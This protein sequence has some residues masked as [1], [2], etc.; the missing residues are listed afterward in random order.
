MEMKL[1]NIAEIYTG[2]T[3]RPP[4]KSVNT[5][6]LKT[7]QIKDLTKEQVIILDDQLVDLEWSYES[8]PQYLKH[9]SLIVV[10]R[11]EPRAYVFKGQQVDQV[12]VSIQFIVVNLNVDNIKP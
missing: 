11:G 1:K 4:E 3:Q 5:F 7:I 8:K 10:A 12:A 9:N 6:D 2:F